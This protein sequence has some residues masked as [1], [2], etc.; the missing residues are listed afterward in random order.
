MTWVE[1][2]QATAALLLVVSLLF[3]LFKFHQD[4][5][6]GIPQVRGW[7]V[8]GNLLQ[9]Q[10]AQSFSSQLQS[11]SKAYGPNLLVKLGQRP[12]VISNTFDGIC[13]FWI[14][15]QSSLISRPTLHTFHKV[16]SSS[17]AFTIGTSPWDQ[18]CKLR[19]KAAALSL[20]PSAV[21]R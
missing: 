5:I 16:I 18:S 7:P 6:K 17:E 21:H 1:G 15:N 12:V 8:V 3:S 13:D 20:N 10:R 11:W 14:K 4:N 9:L 19:R 2:F